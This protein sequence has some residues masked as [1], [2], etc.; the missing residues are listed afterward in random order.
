MDSHST[1]GRRARALA[2]RSHEARGVHEL[3]VMESVVDAITEQVGDVKVAI[4]H[5]EIGELAGVD[6]DALQF[7]FDVCCRGTDL[8]GAE[9]AIARIRGRARCRTCGIEGPMPH[10]GAPCRCGSFDREL[11][12]GDELRLKDVEV[13]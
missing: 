12:A 5:L 6:L 3:A 4:V 8:D 10:L 2:P 1:A 7:C 13:L 11:T 9:L